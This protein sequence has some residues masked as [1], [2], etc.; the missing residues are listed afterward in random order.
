MK[1][2]RRIDLFLNTLKI[3]NGL[4]NNNFLKLQFPRLF[5]PMRT[6]V[7]PAAW[8]KIMHLRYV[9]YELYNERKNTRDCQIGMQ[10]TR[11]SDERFGAIKFDLDWISRRQCLVVRIVSTVKK[12]IVD[13]GLSWAGITERLPNGDEVREKN[14]LYETTIFFNFH[15]NAEFIIQHF[16]ERFH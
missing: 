8:I 16:Y 1:G 11:L 10:R 7:E 14:V 6:S 2:N 13:V 4:R 3:F 12:K 15:K 9:L 5:Q